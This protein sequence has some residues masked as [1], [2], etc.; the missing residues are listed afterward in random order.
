M[1]NEEKLNRALATPWEFVGEPH[2]LLQLLRSECLRLKEEEQH[3]LDE[4]SY[5][6][7]AI[8]QDA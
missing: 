2:V 5:L 6:K 3:L 7:T 4:I 1:T 8:N